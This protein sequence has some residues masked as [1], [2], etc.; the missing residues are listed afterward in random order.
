MMIRTTTNAT[1]CAV[2]NDQTVYSDFDNLE[3][4]EKINMNRTKEVTLYDNT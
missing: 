2:N 4:N 3:S 1:T